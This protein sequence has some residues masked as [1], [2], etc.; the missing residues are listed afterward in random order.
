MD[1]NLKQGR[2][3]A[4]FHLS[5]GMLIQSSYDCTTP[6]F[7]L[8]YCVGIKDKRGKEENRRNEIRK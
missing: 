8:H 5:F 2:E 4:G 6:P 1:G 3:I 7:Q